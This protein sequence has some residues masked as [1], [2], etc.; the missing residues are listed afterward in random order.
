MALAPDGPRWPRPNCRPAGSASSRAAPASGP[1]R[2]GTRSRPPGPNAAPP[3]PRPDEA[4]PSGSSPAPGARGRRAGTAPAGARA[5]SPTAAT[6]ARRR[7][8]ESTRT[9]S[10][11]KRTAEHSK[12]FMSANNG[13]A[14][15][16]P[17]RVSSPCDGGSP[18]GQRR[19]G[20]AGCSA[21]PASTWTA[22][23]SPTFC[24]RPDA[25]RLRPPGRR[26]GRRPAIFVRR[27]EDRATL[28]AR[29]S[30]C[31][32]AGTAARA[33]S[34]DRLPRL[35]QDER[36]EPPADPARPRHASRARRSRGRR[37][38]RRGQPT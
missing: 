37:P 14:R 15:F 23:R 20:S 31:S 33:R 38:P 30:I 32:G 6:A 29:P 11:S 36:R 16:D 22:A 28:R 25:A 17:V 10:R 8:V 21:G 35:R 2:L 26:P 5:R 18:A 19:A 34:S 24:P 9:P 3:P 7:A 4:P 1:D 12:R 27:R 13:V